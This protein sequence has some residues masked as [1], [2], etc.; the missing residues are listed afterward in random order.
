MFMTRHVKGMDMHFAR[1]AA[2]PVRESVGGVFLFDSQAVS[3]MSLVVL[4][5]LVGSYKIFNFCLLSLHNDG[6]CTVL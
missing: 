2:P 3:V 5:L 1:R 4:L 6:L